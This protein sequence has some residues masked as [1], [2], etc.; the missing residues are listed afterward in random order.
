M[1]LLQTRL[2]PPPP[3]PLLTTNVFAR[4]IQRVYLLL[5]EA[6]A[7]GTRDLGQRARRGAGAA[8]GG[9]KKTNPSPFSDPVEPFFPLCPPSY[10]AP[11]QAQG[12]ARARERPKHDRARHHCNPLCAVR[13][14]APPSAME[15]YLFGIRRQVYRLEPTAVINSDLECVSLRAD[16]SE[17]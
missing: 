17:W 6:K 16:T 7:D 1:D 13:R 10:A 11:I 2:P 4:D 12:C 8:Q 9:E 3:L 5:N 15:Q 14:S